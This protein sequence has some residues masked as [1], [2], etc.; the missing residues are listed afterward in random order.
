MVWTNAAFVS[1]TTWTDGSRN[2]VPN[3]PKQAP[4][5]VE[6]RLNHIYPQIEAESEVPFIWRIQS[7]G[8]FYV[9]S[10]TKVYVRSSITEE[11]P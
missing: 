2:T 1:Q 3:W 5:S 6:T 11:I 7:E 8:P 10:G 4:V 9:A